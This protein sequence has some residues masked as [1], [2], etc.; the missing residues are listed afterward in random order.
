[1]TSRS[2]WVLNQGLQGCS[3][4]RMTVFIIWRDVLKRL[5]I[6]WPGICWS[7]MRKKLNSLFL[8]PI[9]NLKK[10]QNITIRIGSANIIP[11]DHIRNLGLMMDMFC[12]NTRHINHLSSSLCQ[13]V[14]NIRNI[15]GKL[16]FNTAKTVVQALILSKLDY[17]N[18]LLV[19]TPGCHLSWLQCVQNMACRVVCNLRKYD[20][21]SAS[22]YSL[23]WLKVRECITFNIAYLVHCCKMGSAPHYLRD[24]LPSA[25]H[26][27]SLRSSTSGSIPSAKCW[28]SLVSVGS[29][30]VVGPKIWNSLPP[31][32]RSEK[33]SDS[34]RKCLKTFL[35]GH[36]YPMDIFWQFLVTILYSFFICTAF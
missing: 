2:T 19:G 4:L 21:V 18:S 3:Q 14:R 28:T 13:Q 34:F 9:N 1:M 8:E 29:F 12:K 32:V 20:H 33:S 16:D 26:N 35:F 7:W 6:G 23:H 25:T 11:A 30:S 17:C 10:I 27:H 31:A 15:R 36:S 22:M 24:V 5:R